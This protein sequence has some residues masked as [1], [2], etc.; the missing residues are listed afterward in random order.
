MF[1]VALKIFHIYDGPA[2]YGERKPGVPGKSTT[3]LM[4]VAKP[5]NVWPDGPFAAVACKPFRPPEDVFSCVQSYI[6]LSSA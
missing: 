5:A 3:L 1:Y 6:C 2:I 4:I